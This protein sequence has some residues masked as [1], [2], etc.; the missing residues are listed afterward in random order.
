MGFHAYY[1][2][3]EAFS[4]WKI[5]DLFLTQKDILHSNSLTTQAGD[6]RIMFWSSITTTHKSVVGQHMLTYVD[7][8][9]TYT[10]RDLV[11]TLLPSE[12]L[13]KHD[14]LDL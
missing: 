12:V 9:S 14:L 3:V 13:Q 1:A 7:C 11:A 2:S 4:T 10:L 5:Y 8:K 6:R